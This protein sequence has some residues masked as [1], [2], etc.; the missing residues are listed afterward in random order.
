MNPLRE[1]IFS[2]RRYRIKSLKTKAEALK[3]ACEGLIDKIERDGFDAY[4]SVNAGVDK[5][6]VSINDTCRCLHFLRQWEESLDEW[7]REKDK[8]REDLR[9]QNSSRSEDPRETEKD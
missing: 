9:G 7:E 4:Y 8:N 5:M 3:K 1:K 6:A 2:E